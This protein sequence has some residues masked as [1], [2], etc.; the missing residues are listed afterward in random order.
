MACILRSVPMPSRRNKSAQPSNQVD[1]FADREA[2]KYAHPIASREHILNLL[3][4]IG[5]PIGFQDLAFQLKVEDGDQL[6]G[7]R[8]R[9]NAM[10]RDGQI[11]KNR[12]GAFGLTTHMDLLPGR[13]Q[14]N[15]DGSGFFIPDQGTTDLYL[16]PREMSR[17]FDG[18]RVLVH[19]SAIDQRG[20]REAAVVE[21]LQRKQE[22]FVGRYY[23][24]SG[25][26][27]VAPDSN[28]IQH[29]ILVANNKA[30]SASNGQYVIVRVT[31]FPSK[32]RKAVGEVV[33][34]LGDVATPGIEIDIALHSF[35]IPHQWPAAVEKEVAAFPEKVLPADLLARHDLRKVPLVTIDGEDAKD[36][37]DAVF[38]EQLDNGAW[39]L[40]VAIADVS[41]Y[42]GLGT[43][44]DEEAQQRG[45]SVYFPGHVVPMLPE[46]LSNGL[47][48]LKPE[49]DRLA[50]ICEI[51]ILPSG[52]MGGYEFSEAVIHSHAR[53]TYNEV[54]DMLQTSQSDSQQNLQQRLRA[55]L[56]GPVL[57][58][59][60][61][62]YALFEAR[63]SW[64]KQKG[65]MDFDTPETRIV[66]GEDKKIREIIPVHR[67]DAHQ[68]IE[69]CML[70]ANV[71]AA[72]LFQQLEQPALYRVHQ[73]PNPDRLESLR[74]FLFGMGL[75]LAGGEE[76]SPSDYQQVLVQIED[77][78]DRHMLQTSLIRSM[79]QAVYQP[80]NIGHFGL[81]FGAYTHFTSPIRRYPDL[82]VHRAIRYLVRNKQSK[83]LKLHP[84][85]QPLTRLS[86]YPYTASQL[87][88]LGQS[89]S[90][91]ERRADAASYSVIDWL[92]CEYM[93]D[94]VGEEFPGTITS[95]TSFG[96][97]VELDG[98][99]IEGLVHITDLSN[100]YY[101]YDAIHHRLDGERNGKSYRLG[102]PVE[103][104]VTR[105]D[106][107]EKK[108]DL[109]LL[110]VDQSRG[111]KMKRRPKGDAK[112]KASKKE[113]QMRGHRGSA[114][115]K[116]NKS[117]QG[118][119]AT[120]KKSSP[121]KSQRKSKNS[122]RKKTRNTRKKTRNKR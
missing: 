10:T 109:H 17:L 77:R 49:V 81:G 79:M 118:K 11:I 63:R 115:K 91:C 33:E 31:E 27:F 70:C 74:E 2:K 52:E 5:E 48:S 64:R 117:K 43:S 62:L 93:S 102:D 71:A 111:R 83:H 105:V 50:M 15:K 29:E 41:H 22:E 78:P 30:K 85:Q 45:T 40:V 34:I 116:G 23:R 98:V 7:L 39:R 25:F 44:L 53:L 103:V 92:K 60:D 73:G 106:L 90:D 94:R 1:P 4:E 42:V 61:A 68:L 97:F 35:A 28:R 55:E 122:A 6:E 114:T 16:P 57:D 18:D 58:N 119:S 3:E 69:E 86:I 9:L 36:F 21:I 100:D 89:C 108:I 47:C 56:P 112:G 19:A 51:E 101:H 65:A 59:L 72:Q 13:V 95:V 26:G 99:F 82:L 12:K 8:K 32:R 120:T 121:G 37:D 88:Q 24:D 46:A 38:A 54:A 110:G 96:L 20:R 75:I 104:K 84:D 107:E 80:Q 76:P 87:E 113:K 67:N 66:F 14:G